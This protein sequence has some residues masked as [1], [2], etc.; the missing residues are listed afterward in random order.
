MTDILSRNS[1]AISVASFLE[2]FRA[3]KFNFDPAFQRRSV[4]DPTRRGFF[5]DSL[6]RNY[7]I[8]PVF[9]HQ[10]ID[11]ETGA[12]SY[13]VVDGKQR[14]QSIAMFIANEVKVVNESD[15]DQDAPFVGRTFAEFDSSELVEYKK[16]FWRYL[17]PVEYL[18]TVDQ[19]VMDE[20]FDRLNRNGMPL[21]SQELR[22]AQFHNT[23][24]AALIRELATTEFWRELLE[25]IADK[26]RFEHEEFIADLCFLILKG[27]VSNS[28]AQGFDYQYRQAVDQTDAAATETYRIIFQQVTEWLKGL[29]LD[30]DKLGIRGTSHLYGLWSLACYV[31]FNNIKLDSGA[32]SEKLSN[33][34]GSTRS[35]AV[36]GPA[37]T[38][39]ISTNSRTRSRA[40]R[41][42]RLDALCEIVGIKIPEP[43]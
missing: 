28:E 1:N 39:F 42:R 6:L 36:D 3:N 7:P 21:S 33:F 4:W 17:I 26:N 13:D 40:Q 19:Q 35:A 37:K 12:T 24:F 41:K 5:I 16:R 25:P 22:N 2:L 9:L 8:P 30:V 15:R 10:H 29:H 34:L 23:A 18:D 32:T 20:V 27:E 43:L 11:T 31:Y 14:L 38:Y